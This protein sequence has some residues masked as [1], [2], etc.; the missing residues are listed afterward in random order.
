MRELRK[1]DDACSKTSRYDTWG[2]TWSA[3]LPKQTVVKVR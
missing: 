2:E 1:K 3:S